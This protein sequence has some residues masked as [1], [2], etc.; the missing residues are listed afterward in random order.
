[1]KFLATQQ[2]TLPENGDGLEVTIKVVSTATQAAISDLATNKTLEGRVRV[3]GFLLRNV[4]AEVKIDGSKFDPF[5][6]A[7][8]ADISDGETLTKMLQIGAKVVSNLF[9]SGDDLKK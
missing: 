4:V 9:P 5:F 8:S 1:V 3:V 2:Q 7:E 6:L